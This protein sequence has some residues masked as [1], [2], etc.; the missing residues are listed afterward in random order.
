MLPADVPRYLMGV[1]FPDDLLE[2]IARGV[3]LFDCVAATRNGR[4]GTRMDQHGKGEHPRGPSTASP[5]RRSIRRATARPAPRFSRGYLRHLFMAEE[6]LGLRLVSLHNI[7]F[8]VRL[9]EQARAAIRQGTLRPL[10]RQDW[11]RALPPSR[12]I[13]TLSLL[14]LM[15]PTDRLRR[16]P[17]HAPAPDRRDRPGLLLPDPPAAAAGPEEARGAAREPQEGR[18]G[19]DRGRVHG[20]GEGHQ[21]GPG[22]DRVRHRD[23]RGGPRPASSRSATMPPAPGSRDEPARPSPARLAGAPGGAPSRWTSST[24]RS[25]GS[26]TTCSRRCTRPR[27]WGSRPTRS[28]VAIRVAVVDAEGTRLV[29]MNP[30]D[31]RGVRQGDGRG[32]LPVDSRPLRRRHPARPGRARGAGPRTGTPYRLERDGSVRPAPSSTRSTT[33]TASSSSTT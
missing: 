12:R 25:G 22:H 31:R 20:Q 6:M 14:A 21:G 1:G 19:D 16:G 8:L 4:H 29:L 27:G 17:Q 23:G 32:G 3:D 28:G 18:R 15:A 11:L 26:S 10:G 5:R 33:S 2:G 13:V 9:A 30:R 24:T 7:R